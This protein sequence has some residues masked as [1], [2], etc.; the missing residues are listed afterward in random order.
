VRALVRA[1]CSEI[2]MVRVRLPLPD[3]R[4]GLMLLV[5]WLVGF[6][7]YCAAQLSLR[8]PSSSG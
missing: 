3:E 4:N 1:Q 8:Y 7:R 2:A 5:R 6:Q